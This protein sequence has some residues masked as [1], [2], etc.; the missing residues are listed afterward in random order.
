MP[1]WHDALDMEFDLNSSF[2]KVPMKWLY[3][4]PMAYCMLNVI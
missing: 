1:F 2:G 3:S 4:N